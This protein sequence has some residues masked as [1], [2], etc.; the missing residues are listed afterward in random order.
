MKKNNCFGIYAI[1]TSN[2]CKNRM[3]LNTKTIK[4]AV[5]CEQKLANISETHD[6]T[7]TN[8]NIKF[9]VNHGLRQIELKHLFS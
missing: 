2:N 6:L 4:L 5:T 8:H 1:E 9:M 3:W 7:C